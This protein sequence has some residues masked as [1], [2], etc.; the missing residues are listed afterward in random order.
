M[1]YI[2]WIYEVGTPSIVLK[3]KMSHL[4]QRKSTGNIARPQEVARKIQPNRWT[5][6][7]RCTVQL[8]KL[9]Q[10]SICDCESNCPPIKLT[11]VSACQFSR[12]IMTSC[13]STINGRGKLEHQMQNPI[14]FF[15]WHTCELAQMSTTYHMKGNYCTKVIVE[16]KRP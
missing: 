13:F 8:S 11:F 15:Q 12:T 6:Q 3:L 5:R 10:L 14:T 7:E 4:P 16:N 1:F 2:N 9:T